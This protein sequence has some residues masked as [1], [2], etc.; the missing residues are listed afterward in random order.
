[1]EGARIFKLVF[2]STLPRSRHLW[3][4]LVGAFTLFDKLHC[5]SILLA[6]FLVAEILLGDHFILA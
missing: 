2:G 1:M 4:L 5:L 3:C 6:H